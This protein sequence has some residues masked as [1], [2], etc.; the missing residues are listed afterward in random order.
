VGERPVGAGGQPGATLV[1]ASASP[2]R[3]QLLASL[4]L[5]PVV[6]PADVDETP[7]ADEAPVALVRRLATTKASTVARADAEVVLAADTEVALDGRSLG[8]P[9]DDDH[10]AA[11]LRSL[12]GRTHPVVTGIAVASAGGVEVAHVATEVT[13]SALSDEDIAWYVGTG[14]PMGKAGAYAIQ[15]AGAVLVERIDGS[16][17][18]VVGLPLAETV[19]LLRRAGFEPLR[20]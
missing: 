8:K 4:G 14:E 6:R 18:N 10:A 9:R 17:S 16:A 12:A 7:Q 11:M 1:L 2:R 5:D 19:A 20:R 3:R 13:F 15:G